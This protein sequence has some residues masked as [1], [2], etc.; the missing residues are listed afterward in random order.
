MI[1]ALFFD[2]DGTLLN[3]KGRIAYS[4]IKALKKCRESGIMV[5]PATGRPPLL[6]HTLS[7][8]GEELGLF[9]DGGIFYNGGCVCQGSCKQY[10]TLDENT[11]TVV[12]KTVLEYQNINLAVQMI[13]ERHSFNFN[14][15]EEHLSLWGITKEYVLP[16]KASGNVDPVKLFMFSPDDGTGLHELRDALVPLIRDSANIYLTSKNKNLEIVGKDISKKNGIERIIKCLGIS[17][18]EIAVFGDDMNDIEMLAGFPHSIAMGNACDEIKAAAGYTALD[19]NSDGIYHALR[20][21][22]G[23]TL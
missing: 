5:F 19:N 15:P 21:Y 1:K 17:P 6:E 13:D 9:N 4:S 3:S 16:F 23:I 18:S 11:V 2:L 10:A 20:D 22:L 8:S 14:V 7:L 12:V